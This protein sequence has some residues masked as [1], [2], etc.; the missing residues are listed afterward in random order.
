M[1]NKIIFALTAMVLSLSTNALGASTKG[2]IIEGETK[3]AIANSSYNINPWNTIT[4]KGVGEGN[5]LKLY[6]PYKTIEIPLN[7]PLYKVTDF[8]CD[9][10]IQKDGLWGVE[11]NVTVKTFNGDEDWQLFKK[12]SFQNTKSVIFS[13]KNNEPV[14]IRNG[15]CTHFDVHTY[16][17]Q[18]T[19]I[20]DGIYFGNDEI[21]MRFM[22]V[23]NVKTVDEL[24][25][26]LKTQYDNGKPVKLYYVSPAP[27]FEPFGEEIQAALNTAMNSNIGY[28]DVNISGIKTDTDI[29]LNTQL[30][31]ASTTGNDVMDRFLSATESVEIFSS[32][33]N[34]GFFVSGIYP[35]NDGFTLEIKDNNKNVYTGKCL[36]SKAD[37]ITAKATEILVAGENSTAIRLMVHL[38][39][40]QLPNANLNGFFFAQTGI[41]DSCIVD[42]QFILPS[43]IPVKEGTVLDFN[44]ALLHGN[45]T[46]GDQITIKDDNG[47]ILS[48]DGKITATTEGKLDLFL[49]GKLTATTEISFTNNI[50]ENTTILFMG[51]SLLN[52]NYYTKYFVDMFNEGQVNL[53]GTRGNEGS[54][55]E[56]R[57][58]WSAYDYCNVSAKY[59]FSNPFLNNGK[60]DFDYYMQSNGYKDVNYVVISLGIND[61]NLVGHNTYG[62]ILNYFDKITDSIHSYNPNTK[63]I[64]NTPIM[65]F[66]E[67]ETAYA[68]DKRLGFTSALTNHYSNTGIYISPAYLNLSSY[69]DFKFIE[70]LINEDN[71]NAAMV[72]TDTTHPNLG[73]YKNLAF[74]TYSAIGFLSK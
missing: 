41:L 66:S 69:G 8:Y 49:N 31:S 72:V 20:Y 6:T 40:L 53:L 59:G 45:I 51:D 30:F 28:T 12:Q 52:E 34:T 23:R 33:G 38:A 16:S 14:G 17:S 56:G 27:K 71:Q 24:K 54:K 67:G 48:S 18:Q 57:G 39:Q 5:L 1:K 63:I 9:K 55:H 13:C 50:E 64:I 4:V 26:Y 73:G 21:L 2:I 61:I 70:P 10:V 58:G 11:R 68:K 47:A 3:T 32:N 29:Q 74:A 25:T 36:F 42:K 15:Y 65:P 35:T 60:F 7:S 37:F 46:S 62:E 44:N 43:V 19:N 22:N